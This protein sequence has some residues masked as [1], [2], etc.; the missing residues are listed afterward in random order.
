MLPEK[1]ASS[2]RY[3]WAVTRLEDLCTRV[4]MVRGWV[5][6]DDAPAGMDTSIKG[7][8]KIPNLKFGW[9][10][11]LPRWVW[12]F[13]EAWALFVEM[14]D[15]AEVTMYVLDDEVFCAARPRGTGRATV[16]F[17]KYDKQW[18]EVAIC[19]CYVQWIEDQR[20]RELAA[21]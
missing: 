8:W 20:A 16:S 18:P 3:P 14:A 12:S 19:L 10:R 11:T 9:T 21:E 17:G 1:E 7:W 4:A 6:Q 2:T 13:S 15:S 5:Y